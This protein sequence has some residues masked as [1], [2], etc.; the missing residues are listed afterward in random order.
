MMTQSQLQ[1][2]VDEATVDA[3]DEDEQVMGLFSMIV[4]NLALPFET[5]V[6]GVGVTVDSVDVSDRGDIVAICSRG[7]FQQSI[8]LLELALPTPSPDG[9]EWIEAYR[10]WAGP[11][12][13]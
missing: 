8:S 2:L 5:I 4:D 13:G 12:A 6:L 3:H 9:T 11:A 7:R 10:R 1:A